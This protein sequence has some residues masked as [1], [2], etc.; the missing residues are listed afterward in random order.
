MTFGATLGKHLMAA[1]V[2]MFY[3]AI[4]YKDKT[5]IEVASNVNIKIHQLFSKQ[6]IV[7]V[8]VTIVQRKISGDLFDTNLLLNNV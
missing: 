8:R 3:V 6:R 4:D 2:N 7:G 5:Y 1:S